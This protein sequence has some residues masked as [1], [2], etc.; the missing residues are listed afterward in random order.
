MNGSAPRESPATHAATIGQLT[1]DAAQ[2]HGQ[3]L[4]SLAQDIEWEYWTLENLLAE[5]PRKW[6]LSLIALRDGV[7]VGYAIIS[8]KP[9]SFHLH[10]LIVGQSER[11][12]GL[13]ARL[14]QRMLDDASKAG[15]EQ[16]TLKVLK[17]NTRA[18]EFYLRHG[19]ERGELQQNGYLNMQRA[20]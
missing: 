13:G 20:V 18:I 8:R 1:R 14:L 10:H 19:F 5:L 6:E 17:S 9:Q 12:S 16:F 3:S 11:G 2:K 4:L 15:A 7:P